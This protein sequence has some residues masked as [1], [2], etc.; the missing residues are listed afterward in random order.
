MFEVKFRKKHTKNRVVV[1]VL[2]DEIIN[3]LEKISI[4]INSKEIYINAKSL[5][6]LTRQSKKDRGAGLSEDDILSI[7]KILKSP[8]AIYFDEAKEKLNLLYCAESS[9][10]RVIKIVIDTK[11]IRKKEK[12]TL[13]KTA[14][15]VE[16]SNMKS[17]KLIIGA[18]SR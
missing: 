8:M 18:E 10:K 13:I 16:W 7:P 6:H 12:F 11:Y 2:S 5:S 15:Y 3:F 9:C 1:G 14:G 4:P 17:Y